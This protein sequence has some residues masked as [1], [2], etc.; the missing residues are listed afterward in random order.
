[1][2][3]KKEDKKVVEP[4]VKTEDIKEEISPKIMICVPTYRNIDTDVVN[5]L[6]NDIDYSGLKVQVLFTKHLSVAEARNKFV[7][8]CQKTKIPPDYIWFIDSDTLPDKYSLKRLLSD[9]KDIVSGLY[10]RR[11]WPYPPLIMLENDKGKYNFLAEYPQNALVECDAIGMGNCLIKMDVFDKVEYP[12]F[13]QI[14]SNT[15]DVYFCKKARKKGIEIFVDT[16]TKSKHISEIRIDEESFLQA[17]R[18]ILLMKKINDKDEVY[19]ELDMILK[20]T[21]SK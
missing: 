13:A 7:E 20:K 1:M 21:P 11:G 6:L 3:E 12:W 15:E 19:A 5:A 16:G 2:T 10:F 4:E 9:K 8:L 17:R 18:D 14:G